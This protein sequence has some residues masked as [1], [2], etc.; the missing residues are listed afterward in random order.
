[1]HEKEIAIE[2]WNQILDKAQQQHFSN[3][4]KIVIVLGNASG[5]EKQLLKQILIEDIL[6]NTIASNSLLDIREEEL[7]AQCN[8]C[9]TIIDATQMKTMFCPKCGS[10][11]ILILSG[12]DYFIKNIEGK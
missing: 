8:T 4:T 5:I 9:K 2:L 11:D 7:T 3:V 1:M 10:G 12:N 6:P